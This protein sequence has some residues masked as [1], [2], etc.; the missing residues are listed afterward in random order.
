MIVVGFHGPNPRW[1]PCSGLPTRQPRGRG[2]ITRP[3]HPDDGLLR[4]ATWGLVLG[5]V[6]AESGSG[7]QCGDD[8]G[9]GVAQAH[10]GERLLKCRVDEH[11][12]S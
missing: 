8:A 6:D 4:C 10:R 2:P 12:V 7:Q 3:S 5:Y 9:V 1:P 11:E